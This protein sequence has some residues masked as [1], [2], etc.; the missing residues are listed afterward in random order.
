MRAASRVVVSGLRKRFGRREVLRG[1][2]L[3]IAPGRITAIVGPNAAGKTTLIKTIL[4]LV[5]R[6]HGDGSIQLDGAELNGDAGYRQ[7]IGYMPQAAQFPEQLS[8]REILDLVIGLRSP[9]TGVRSFKDRLRT[10]ASGLDTELIEHFRLEEIIDQ[11]VRT[12]SG[13]TRQK[14]NAAVAFLF[15]PT[16]LILDEPTAGLD[17]LAAGIL[18]DK[19][20]RAP[21]EGTTVV[22]TSHL[23]GEVEELAQDLVFLLDGVVAYQGSVDGLLRRMQETRLEPAMARLLQESGR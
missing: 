5:R 14:L 8:G 17:P 10:P 21:A 11:P 1:L 20:R 4:G 9:E 18:K 13:G 19:V 15:R 6:R 23:M 3:A 22:L 7:R 2:D 16:L 12:L